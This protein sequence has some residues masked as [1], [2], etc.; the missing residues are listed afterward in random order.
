MPSPAEH[1]AGRPASRCGRRFG[2]VRSRSAEADGIE[3]AWPR[4]S[5]TPVWRPPPGYP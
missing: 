2:S 5:A 3:P 1:A 4:S